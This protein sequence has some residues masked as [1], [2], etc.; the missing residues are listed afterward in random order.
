MADIKNMPQLLRKLSAMS[1]AVATQVV[2]DALTAG[3][4]LIVN[5]AKE[6]APYL[7]GTLMRSIHSSEPFTNSGRWEMR[8]GTNIEYA[9]IHE[10]GGTIKAKDKPLLAFRIGGKLILTKSVQMPARPYLRPAFDSQKDAV[11]VEVGEALADLV[12][13]SAQ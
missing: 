11:V 8:I 7:S 13:A 9:R 2:G 10:Y 6:N 1:A 12:R 3:A 4:Q 5:D